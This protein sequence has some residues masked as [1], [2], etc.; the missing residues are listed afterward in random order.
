MIE[1]FRRYLRLFTIFML[2]I[3]EQGV[4]VVAA[5]GNDG[6]NE[7]DAPENCR[8]VISLGGSDVTGRRVL[9][10]NTQP[11]VMRSAPGTDIW[12]LSNTGTQAPADASYGYMHR[13]RVA[14]PK[15]SGVVSLMLTTN[16]WLTPAEVASILKRTACL[17]SIVSKTRPCRVISPG[18]GVLDCG[19]CGI[20]CCGRAK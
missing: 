12:T 13:T 16:P 14:A 17:M 15:V 20:G 18:R 8:G 3:V 4:A 7:I 1:N 19:S 9:D 10:S 11:H 2:I 5:A 6:V